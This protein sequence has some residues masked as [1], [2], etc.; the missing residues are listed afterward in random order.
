[1]GELA[2][3]V[4]VFIPVVAIIGGLS[5]AAFHKWTEAEEKRQAMQLSGGGDDIQ[6]RMRRMEE[7]LDLM[8]TEL[9]DTVKDVDDRLL[10]IEIL[11]KEV[12]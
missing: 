7:E 10:R 12:E 5:Y 11:L 3:I 9:T 4:W 1:M 6:R 8:R 2:G